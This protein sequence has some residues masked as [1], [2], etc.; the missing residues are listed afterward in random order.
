MPNINVVGV[1]PDEG[2]AGQLVGN[3]RLAGFKQDDI[4]LIMVEREKGNELAQDDA[5]AGEG[6]AQASGNAAKGAVAGGVVGVLA[7]LGTLAIPGIGPVI[8]TGVLLAMFGGMG[9]AIGGMLGLYSSETVSSEVIERYG[10]ALQE[11]QAVVA[12]TVPDQ[13][14]AQR[15]EELFRNAGAANINSY[16][17]DAPNLDAEP[18][19]TDRNP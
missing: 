5:N 6:V 2:V 4:S 19:L 16:M 1:V 14:E 18:G 3:L 15:A 11:G 12:V 17:G 13:D 8:G 7:G 9:T 10:M